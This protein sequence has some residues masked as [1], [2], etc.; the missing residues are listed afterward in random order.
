MKK[1]LISCCLLCCTYRAFAL[2][3]LYEDELTNHFCMQNGNNEDQKNDF[4]TTNPVSTIWSPSNVNVQTYL[5]ANEGK[6]IGYKKGYTS[7]GALLNF[8]GFQNKLIQSFI[9]ARCHYFNDNRWATNLGIGVRY[10]SPS[11]RKV[12]GCSVFYDFRQRHKGYHQ[13]GL[14]LE[15][16]GCHYD[17]RLNGYLP[18]GNNIGF[19]KPCKST[20]PGGYFS[21]CQTYEKALHGCDAEIET[22]LKRWTNYPCFD[23]YFALGP[24]YYHQDCGCNIAG[25]KLRLG[26]NY[27]DCI[28]IEVRASYDSIFRTCV[29]GILSVNIPWGKQ[30]TSI[31]QNECPNII[32]QRII[33]HPVQRQEIIVESKKQY[34][35][36]INY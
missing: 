29:Q 6:G 5:R 11:L 33:D 7:L 31:C 26:F 32:W 25:G 24:Y 8:R 9:D 22:S 28:T 15:M 16:L 23:P 14:G 3:S 19:S 27:L 30:Q 1:I 17:I 12:F 4:Q 34:R 36:K 20:Y 35:W 13:V 18:I 21:I 2:N 10:L